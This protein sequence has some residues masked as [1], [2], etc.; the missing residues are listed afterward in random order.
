MSTTAAIT[1]RLALRVRLLLPCGEPEAA[2]TCLE[3]LR[4]NSCCLTSTG[5]GHDGTHAV[6]PGKPNDRRQR[7]QKR[8]ASS[9]TLRIVGKIP[10]RS[11]TFQNQQFGMHK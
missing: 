7:M 9:R 10:Y 11:K 8:T 5:F 6:G 2:S 4:I 1:C 3:R